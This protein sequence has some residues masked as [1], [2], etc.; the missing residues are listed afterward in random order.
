MARLRPLVTVSFDTPAAL[1]DG[2][3]RS[4]PPLSCPQALL[5]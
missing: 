5:K 4:D 2:R 3:G 1:L